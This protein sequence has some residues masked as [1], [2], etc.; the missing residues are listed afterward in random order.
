MEKMPLPHEETERSEASF[1]R[2]LWR[3]LDI[4]GEEGQGLVEYGM[5]LFL[6]A[7][8]VFAIL[9]IL[10]PQIGSMFSVVTKSFT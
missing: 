2:K 1:L 7:V 9:I 6:I 10:G 8:V 5:V 3:K 4:D